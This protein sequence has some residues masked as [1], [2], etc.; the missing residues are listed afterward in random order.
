LRDLQYSKSREAAKV[1]LSYQKQKTRLRREG[2]KMPGKLEKTRPGGRAPSSSNWDFG[3][4][5]KERLK[6]LT[7]QG[8]R[9]G[10][11]S[12]GEE[13]KRSRGFVSL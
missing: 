5:P 2:F 3:N 11:N 12:R 7:T 4:L 9:K 10:R 6:F 8:E 1:F 13:G